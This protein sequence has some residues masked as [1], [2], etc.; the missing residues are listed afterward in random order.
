MM[1]LE[2][3]HAPRGAEVGCPLWEGCQILLG[4]MILTRSKQQSLNE[5]SF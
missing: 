4:Y 2:G 1:E 3:V 5:D